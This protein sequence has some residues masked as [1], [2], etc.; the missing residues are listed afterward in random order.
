MRKCE[1]LI[2]AESPLELAR[3]LPRGVPIV[4]DRKNRHYLDMTATLDIETSA[5]ES[6]GII[7]SIQL[8]IGGVNCLIRHTKDFIGIIGL[9]ESYYKLSRARRLVIYV[10]NLGFEMYW[11]SQ[12]ILTRYRITNQLYT[13]SHKPIQVTLNNGIEF[14]D[15][16]KLFQKSLAAAT[17]GLPH[18]KRA[19]DLDY[20][21]WRTSETPLTDEEYAYCI[22][23]VQGLWEAIERLK[24][25]RGY[26]SAT[27][28]LT[29][30]AMVIEEVNRYIRC[31]K[32]TMEAIRAVR[33]DRQQTEICYKAIGGGDTHGCRWKAGIT[34]KNCNSHDKKS[35]HPSQ[36][37][38]EK[39]PM[40]IPQTVYD[41]TE[42]DLMRLAQSGYGWVGLLNLE[43]LLIRMEC[44]NPPISVSKCEEIIEKGGVDNGRLLSCLGVS[45]YC[46]SNDYVRIADAY[47]YTGCFL[48]VGVIFHLD[49]LPDSFRDAI[50]EKF[51]Y[52]EQHKDGADY[53]FSKICVNTIYGACAQKRVRDEYQIS[54]D[55]GIS[56]VKTDWE[57]K[58]SGM[59]DDQVY[60]T[61][62]MKLP[63]LWGLWTASLS[64]LELWKLQKACGWENLIYWDT[65][66]VK[67]E[68]L[69]NLAISAYNE[70]IKRK[71]EE[72]G[73][74][75][76]NDKGE[77]VYIGIAENEHEGVEY[78][79]K[80]FR[81]LHAKCYCGTEWNRK[82]G[83]YEFAVTIAGVG[84]KEG[85]KA[86]RC[87]EDLRD[88]FYIPDAGGNKL[89]Y[90]SRPINDNL[91]ASYVWMEP[92]DYLISDAV[93]VSIEQEIIGG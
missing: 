9:L 38:L 29:N 12:A 4:T 54:Y 83:R 60:K 8:N 56:A 30:T 91:E 31:D 25:E 32:N 82:T 6:Q 7:Y 78:G 49:Y 93:S 33:L 21:I 51:K 39:Y 69:P 17:A 65:D 72:R 84:K 71:C 50:L 62:V 80:R 66:S 53:N 10:H 37:L 88:G 70:E 24:Q 23:D 46:D 26:N 85:V 52:K 40:G 61:Q 75:I 19:G 64:R 42:E 45:V 1:D 13:G 89:H 92:R 59:T 5:D 15:T 41:Y 63:F 87:E 36:M 34:L 81:F 35:A 76:T 55:E 18:E 43:N 67:Y 28:P 47:H 86:L 3:M 74:V 2:V 79:Y 11:L 44:P 14:R 68:G 48:S 77:A 16:L 58:L 90:V 27:I 73:C 57:T 20:Q 22:Y